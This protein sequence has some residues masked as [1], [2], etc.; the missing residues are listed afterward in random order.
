MVELTVLGISLQEE[1]STPVLL[2][3]PHGTRR[4]LSIRI[5]PMEAFAIST[6]LHEV[7]PAGERPDSGRSPSP[8]R[9]SR[10]TDRNADSGGHPAFPRPL[11]HDLLL[12]VIKALDARLT[13]VDL[14]DLLDGAFLAEAVLDYPGGTARVD[15]RP[16]DGIALA[17]RCGAAVRASDNV[18]SYAE[19]IDLVMAGLP[20]HVRTLAAAKLA[21]LPGSPALTDRVLRVPPAIEAALAAKARFSGAERNEECIS[22]ARKMLI[23]DVLSDNKAP[24]ALKGRD[25]ETPP[26]GAAPDPEKERTP[27]RAPKIKIQPRVVFIGPNGEKSDAPPEDMP[28]IRVTMVRHGGKGE[29]EIINTFNVSASG[30][31]QDVLTSLGLSRREAEAV[32]GASDEE[33]WATLLRLLSPETKVPM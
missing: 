7:G 23:D 14:M 31:P 1:D 18:V 30:I 11:T 3:H 29:Q 17:L 13:S 15:C 12:S 10:Q 26:P 5:G 22:A 24:D 16:S 19:G 32:N 9:R 6:A 27:I 4:V 28:Q 20:E 33:R 2:L 8:D 21:V 25:K